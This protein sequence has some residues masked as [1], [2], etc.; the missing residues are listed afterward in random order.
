MADVLGNGGAAGLLRMHT[1]YM[2]RTTQSGPGPVRVLLVDDH[3]LVRQGVRRLLE[4]DGDI[5]VVAEAADGEELLELAEGIS[6]D[7]AVVDIAMPR[8]NGLDALP[9]LRRRAPGLRV[10]MLSMY[11]TAEYVRHALREGA[12]G[13]VLKSASPTVLLNAVRAVARGELFLCPAVIQFMIDGYSRAADGAG[14]LTPRQRDVLQLIAAGETSKAIAERLNLSVK[15]V[16][17]HRAE[18]SRRLGVKGVAE[19]VREAVRLGLVRAD[20]QGGR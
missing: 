11:S 8:L 2:A 16:E 1:R 5:H 10:V 3:R 13:Y 18:I 20:T 4:G 17:T 15:T 19:V 12:L 7:V 14:C 6:A 9:Q